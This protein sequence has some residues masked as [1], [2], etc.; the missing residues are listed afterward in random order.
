MYQKK[1]YGK[2]VFFV[3]SC[4]SGGIFSLLDNNINVYASS[5]S[6]KYHTSSF[7]YCGLT[8][9]NSTNYGSNTI[10]GKSIGSCLSG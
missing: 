6:S 7:W 1:R 3:E 9:Y 10:N 2:L 5:S 4:Y 8:K